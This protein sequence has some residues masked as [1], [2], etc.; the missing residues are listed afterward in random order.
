MDYIAK[1][2]LIAKYQYWWSSLLMKKLEIR[3]NLVNELAEK[4][5]DEEQFKEAIDQIEKEGDQKFGSILGKLEELESNEIEK[6]S[7][8]RS[9]Q[10]ISKEIE[11]GFKKLDQLWDEGVIKIKKASS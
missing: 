10:G 9:S 4:I 5:D 8:N 11:D 2:K 6:L 1:Q 7:E 3:S